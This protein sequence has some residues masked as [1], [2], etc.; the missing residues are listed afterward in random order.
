MLISVTVALLL[1]LRLSKQFNQANGPHEKGIDA[2]P[3]G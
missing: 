1:E 3:E 2:A